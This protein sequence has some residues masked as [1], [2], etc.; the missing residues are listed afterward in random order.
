MSEDVVYELNL[1]AEGGESVFLGIA[2]RLPLIRALGTNVL[3][4]MPVQPAGK[5]RSAG[6]LGSPYAVADYDRLNPEFGTEAEFKALIA[7]AHRLKMRVILDWVANHTAWDHPWTKEHPDWYTRDAKGEIRIPAGTNWNDAADLDFASVSLRR[8]MTRAMQGWVSRYGIDGFR[9]DTADWVPADY[10]KSAIT[11]LRGSAKRPL[12]M[13][14]EGARADHYASGFDL[15]YGWAFAY[16][17]KEAFAGKSAREVGRADAEERKA[18]PAGKGPLRFSSN[19]DWAAWDGTPLEM[20]RTPAGVRSAFLVTALSGGA[21]L[22]YGGQEVGWDRR[23]PIFDRSAIDWSSG[24]ETRRW[25]TDLLRLRQNHPALRTGTSTDLSTDDA[26]AFWRRAGGEEALVLA[27]VRDAAKGV[28]VPVGA[29]GAWHDG[30]TGAKTTVGGTIDLPAYG[31]RVLL[32]ATGRVPGR[33][34]S[35]Q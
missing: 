22:I 28:E 21:P 12:L 32:R 3:W 14:A 5:L 15:T 8:A 27:N 35:L 7:E 16:R 18:A 20:F 11:A 34:R 29:R 1:R 31:A 23:V 24:A 19:H 26:V 30:L 2:Q 13:L 25:I 33:A 4:L 9:C 17:L 6:G 10:W